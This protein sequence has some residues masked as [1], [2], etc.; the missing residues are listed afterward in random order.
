MKKYSLFKVPIW[1]LLVPLLL[2]FSC[3]DGGEV[4]KGGE[5]G[6]SKARVCPP[7][8][9][10]EGGARDKILLDGENFGTDQNQI[11]VYFNNKKA[12]IVSSSGNRIYA[13]VPRLPG[14]NPRISVVI[15]E[16]SVIYDQRFNYTPQAQV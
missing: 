6:P 10:L 2:F 1:A 16:D 3:Q 5:D 8:Y 14:V 4:R 11:K 15:G 13:I 9:P 12:A 7:F